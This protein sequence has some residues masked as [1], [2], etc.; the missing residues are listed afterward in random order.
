MGFVELMFSNQW[1]MRGRHSVSNT[2]SSDPTLLQ[3]SVSRKPA[4]AL[5][6]AQLLSCGLRDI[7]VDCMGRLFY[8]VWNR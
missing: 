5:V 1:Q 8:H 6:H 4:N 3:L 2:L 7:L